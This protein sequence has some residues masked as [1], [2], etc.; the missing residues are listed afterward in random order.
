[1]D[2]LLATAARALAGGDPLGALKCVALRSDPP[3]LALRGIALAQLGQYAVARRLLQRAQRGFG[4]GEVL[5]RARCLTAEA[6]IALRTHGHDLREFQK[7]LESASR[8]LEAR[9]DVANALFARLLVIRGLLAVGKVGAAAEALSRLSLSE[10]PARLIAVA[11]LLRADVAVLELRSRDAADAIERAASAAES[12]GIPPLRSEVERAR[13]ELHAVA[14]RLAAGEAETP[15]RLAEIEALL[16]SGAFV[17]DACRRSVVAGKQSVSLVS[18]PV[19]F[20]L[21]LSL[22]VAAPGEVMR[23]VLIAAAFGARRI[24]DS[25]R[26]RLRVEIGRLRRALAAVAELRATPNG[27]ALIPRRAA[28][29]VRLLPPSESET[30]ALSALLARG[31]PWSSSALS[32]AL[33]KSQRSVQRALLELQAAGRVRALGKG[34]AQRWLAP[35]STGIT[36]AML[37]VARGAL[38]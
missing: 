26:A 38:G 14:A 2:S 22:G 3:S 6:E 34:R 33:G 18:R 32:A 28:R 8:E 11:E 24:N 10:V 29:V 19:L 1:M 27:F 37:L 17:I 21:A 13:T 36:T 7:P 31:E 16:G 12:A 9:G 15:L 35:E 30:S 4:K 20:E 25:H 5:A 23:D